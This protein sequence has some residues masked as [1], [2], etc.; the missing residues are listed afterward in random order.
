MQTAF[1]GINLGKASTSMTINATASTLLA[2]YI[3]VGK[4]QGISSKELRGTT[5]N[6]ILKEYVARNTYIYPPQPSMRII[7]DMIGYCAKNVP[8]WY[9]IS[10]SGYHMREAGSTAVQEIAFTIA[11]G[12]EYI[13]TCIDRGL[14]IDDFAPRLSFFFCC[15]IEFFEEVAK[16][17]TA[18]K[19]YAKILKERFHAKNPKS[20]QLRFHTQTSGE[21]LT[22]QQPDNNIVRVAV[23]AMAA[24]LGGT[25][26]LHTNSRDEALALPSQEAAKIALR[27]QQ[28]IGY[29]S[30]VTKTV[31]PMAGSYYMESLCDEIEE[32]VWDYLKKIDKMGGALKAIEK[33]FFQSEIRQNAYRLKKEVDDD[34]RILVGV[35]KFSEKSEKKQNL[36]RIDDSLGKKQEKAIK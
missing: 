26:S 23:Q 35:N 2:Y 30:G 13:Q 6:D 20:L 22:A 33:G 27:T 19:I 21:S 16:F 5:Q 18:R 29:E 12:I 11:N 10:I 3:A 34:Q 25:Q 17:R 36:L 7:G 9:P 28:I 32:Q 15:T 4:S 31:D 1:N 24:V 14:K 8:Q